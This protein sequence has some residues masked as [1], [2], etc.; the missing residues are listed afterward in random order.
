LEEL[1]VDASWYYHQEET[2]LLENDEFDKVKSELSKRGSRFVNLSTDEVAFVEASIAYYRGAPI[3]SDEEFGDMKDKVQKSG[4]R[5]DMTAFVLYERGNQYLKNDQLAKLEE[6]FKHAQ[7]FDFKKIEDYPLGE[8][9]E[10][11]IDALW[12]YYREGRAIL[13]DAEFDK[14]KQT[15]Y[16]LDS[17]FPT[18]KRQEVAFVEATIAWYRGKPLLTDAEYDVLKAEVEKGDIRKDVT[19]FLLYERGEQFLDDDQFD[20]MKEELQKLGMAAVNL[21]DCTVAQMEEMYVDALW[22]YYNDKV[23]LLSDDQYNKLREE[24]AWQ[25]SGF[26]SLTKDQV[27]FVKASLAYWR[28][29]PI[30]NDEEWEAVKSKVL[31][32]GK[33][34]DVTAF[35]L[36]SKG[37]E[38]LDP[39]TFAQ[40]KDEMR[41]M[42]VEVQ[43][44]GSRALEQ[45]LSI[46][47]DRLQND[48]GEVT[49]MIAAL[50][51]LPTIL[52]IAAVWFIGLALDIGFV[53]DP[54]WGALLS[55]EALP[56]F[57]VGTTLGVLLTIQLLNFLDL[58]NPEVLVGSCPSCESP[59]KQFNGGAAPAQEVLYKCTECGCKMV[60]DTKDR[61]IQ[62]AGLG[63]RIEG[64]QEQ[65]FDWAKA[66]S[67]LKERADALVS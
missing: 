45:T 33:R 32:E 47:S 58:Q 16:K 57:A 20:S 27:S 37:Q 7:V 3:M 54:D 21:E 11:Y 50:G 64:E 39:E 42:G 62:A 67:G 36:Y 51:A 28:G 40:M 10:L 48:L 6:A 4:R 35:L 13:R 44:A 8:L 15:L 1:Y 52:C 66:W 18:L 12:C 60:L 31:A 55:A 9:E 2:N 29:E 30:L 46:T 43:K 49:F 26:P 65:V 24:L 22:A 34:T 59:I 17:R 41:K 19:A 5:K 61:R 25:G 56:L 63:A 53:P 23:Q 14:L 38:T